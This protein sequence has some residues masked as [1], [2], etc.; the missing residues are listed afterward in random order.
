[1]IVV[2]PDPQLGD[3]FRLRLDA[4]VR[5]KLVDPANSERSEASRQQA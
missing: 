2:R 3:T 4:V 5:F 1:M